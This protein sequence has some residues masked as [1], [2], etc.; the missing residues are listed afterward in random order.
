[1]PRISQEI[2]VNLT[3][4]FIVAPI[5][6]LPGTLTADVSDS[7]VSYY[8]P[9]PLESE[10]L[11]DLTSRGNDLYCGPGQVG[12]S[13][14]DDNPETIQTVSKIARSFQFNSSTSDFIRTLDS[15]EDHVLSDGSAYCSFT[16]S[17]WVKID[18]AT[19]N[20]TFVHKGTPTKLEFHLRNEYNPMTFQNDI[21]FELGDGTN[22]GAHRGVKTSSNPITSAGWYHIA[23][24]YDKTANSFLGRFKIYVNGDVQSLSINE[25]GAPPNDLVD[26]RGPLCLG[27]EVG[28]EGTD[29]LGGS[30]YTV[31]IWKRAL[32]EN[33]IDSIYQATNTGLQLD[34]NSGIISVPPR[35][36]LR[37]LDDHP[38]SYST[39]RRTGDVRKGNL[40]S[41]FDDKSTV[42]FSEQTVSFPSLLPISSQFN[43]QSTRIF[44]EDSDIS[45]SVSLRSHQQPNY[46]HYSP[47]EN[48]GPFDDR[49]SRSAIDF[50]MSGTDPSILPG[51]SSPMRS[52][53]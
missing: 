19:T 46:L 16:I 14:S 24:V 12:P 45:T 37:E 39:I 4:K 26:S 44:G 48:M 53:V 21:W 31:G 51:F 17:M 18:D 38:G 34:E 42:V 11:I 7:L 22:S 50:F 32:S 30:I 23:L 35:L 40:A 3:K 49:D 8:V 1:M 52:K 36:K 28:A 2:P 9:S 15:K 20:N 27:C 29:D 25:G 33:E 5:G 10:M 41:N 47:A 13:L 43:L 6:N